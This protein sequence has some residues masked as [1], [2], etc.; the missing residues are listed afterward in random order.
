MKDSVDEM[1]AHLKIHAIKKFGLINKPYKTK[2][3]FGELRLP[4]KS[5]KNTK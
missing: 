2:W 4:E 1:V 5:I 3:W